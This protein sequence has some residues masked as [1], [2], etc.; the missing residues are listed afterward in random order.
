[1][2]T[3]RFALLVFAG[4]CSL[5]RAQSGGE[6][7][8][9]AVPFL[10]DNGRVVLLVPYSTAL[11]GNASL[12]VYDGTGE[13][14][15]RVYWQLGNA[16]PTRAKVTQV[17]NDT[18]TKHL[19]VNLG[20]PL[21]SDSAINTYLWTVLYTPPDDSTVLPQLV[22]STPAPRQ[23][24]A[25]ASLATA[26]GPTSPNKPTFCPVTAGATPDISVTGNFLAAGGTKPIYKLEV[27]SNL[28]APR[29]LWGFYPGLNLTVEVNQNVKP[30]V[31]RT[32]FDP[33]SIVAGLAFQHMCTKCRLGGLYAIRLDETLPG[34]EFSRTDPSSNI[35]AATSVMF[36][37]NSWQPF[38]HTAQAGSWKRRLYGSLY[39]LV[40]FEG[41]KNLNRPNMLAKT[42][43]DLSKYN[44]IARGLLG[45]DAT[46]AL[47]SKDL[48]SDDISLSGYYR[49]R[50]PAFDEP[51]IKTT[52]S[53]TT[54]SLTTKPRHW[55]ELDLSYSPFAFKYIAFTAQYQYGDLPPVFTLVD[56]KVSVGLTLKA[57]QSSKA[58]VGPGL[59]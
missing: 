37:F 44:A 49:V 7:G 34:G 31:N 51:F 26:C 19:V 50:L 22:P 20:A 17:T 16:K 8:S 12:Y 46:L 45:A 25:P 28:Y 35:V 15:W 21:P 47:A 41:G 32:R 30:P 6:F 18:A 58:A 10:D 9:T 39:P 24:A 14:H 3:T 55:V 53:V 4:F 43:V 29:P 1:M 42:L 54:V 52:D 5:L 13:N 48:K 56:H 36:L 40:A 57:A 33:D 27:I 2:R 59:K 23:P 38:L 11:P